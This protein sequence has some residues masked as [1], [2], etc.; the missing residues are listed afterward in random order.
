MTSI[1]KTIE[2]VDTDRLY[3]HLLSLEGVRHALDSYDTLIQASNY[4]EKTLQQSN[5]KI[6]RHFFP[7][8]GLKK[9]FFNIEGLL[10]ERMDLTQPTLLITSHYDTVY[11]TPGADDNASGVAVML[12]VA[13]V[14]HE[15][16]YK[17]NVIFVSFNLEEFSP[18]L[19]KP[20]R[21]LGTQY[22][23]FDEEFRYISWPLKKYA[24]QFKKLIISS[25]PAKPYLDEE[26]WRK[27]E[28]KAKQELN[29]TELIF[30]KKQNEI[31]R[32][33]A[34]DDPFGKSFCLGSD[35]YS[36]YVFKSKMTAKGVINLESVGFVSIEPHSQRLPQGI[37][38]D[39]FKT[40]STDH[41][42]MIG[43]YITVIGDE[44]SQNLSDAFFESSQ[45]KSI[46]LPCASLNVPLDYEGIKQ[47]M[48]D[49]LRSDH[50][51]FWRYSIPAIMVTDT[52]NFRNPYYHTGGD[53]INTI[54][55]PFMKKI[56]QTTLATIIKLL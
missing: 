23:V 25:G 18:S 7:V 10:G 47:T 3:K 28:E 48:P 5:I 29:G 46:N 42:R 13:R 17:K 12:E 1:E 45:H 35:A 31:F 6:N 49:L 36:K 55:F 33:S 54:N 32:E 9:E 51:P 40:H 21:A 41:D 34:Q 24:D 52:A 26:N 44:N 20:I 56:C 4:I 19:Q 43:N 11:S 15:I 2:M 39:M 8:K 27:F 37:S 38:L 53:T 22:G 16:D 14:L 50:A 30:F